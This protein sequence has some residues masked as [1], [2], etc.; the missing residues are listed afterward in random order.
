ME[1]KQS[2]LEEIIESERQLLID[3]DARY[4]KYYRDARACSVFL[5]RSIASVNHDRMM[6]ARFHALLKKH[7]LL[8]LLS[9][10]Y[11]TQPRR[12]FFEIDSLC[13]TLSD[14]RGVVNIGDILAR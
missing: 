3:A 2:T 1:L 4:G 6:F 9:M 8:A 5:S 12:L 10:A 14:C 11:N 13:P 7:H